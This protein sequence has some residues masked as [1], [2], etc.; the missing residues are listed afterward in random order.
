MAEVAKGLPK[1]RNDSWETKSL[2]KWAL[3]ASVLCN[4]TITQ[5][6]PQEYFADK[7]AAGIS[8]AI[9]AVNEGTHLRN[10]WK[11][12]VRGSLIEKGIHA[13]KDDC[14][15]ERKRKTAQNILLLILSYLLLNDT[16]KFGG[17]PVVKTV[18][19]ISHWGKEEVG[20]FQDPR[21]GTRW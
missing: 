12:M 2:A 13:S 17:K 10:A 11:I 8:P 20:L 19:C 9:S 16:D 18:T 15:V 1:R 21:K 3:P 4:P 5:L 14:Y 6:E 7:R